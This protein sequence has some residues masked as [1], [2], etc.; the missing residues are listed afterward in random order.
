MES[1]WL[2]GAQ[3]A[4]QCVSAVVRPGSSFEGH[5]S[6]KISSLLEGLAA[7]HHHYG[8]GGS[9][10]TANST[11]TLTPEN[12]ALPKQAA[13]VALV[14]PVLD[15]DISELLHRKGVFEL[16]V[17]DHPEKL[18]ALFMNVSSWSGVA[19][20]LVESGVAHLIDAEHAPHSRGRRL[21]AGMFGVAKPGSDLRRVR[22]D[23]RRK[24]ACDFSLREVTCAEALKASW[25]TSRMLSALR[26]MTLPHSLQLKDLFLR[27]RS[28]LWITTKDAKDYFYLMQLPHW[29]REATIVGWPVLRHEVPAHMCRHL[30]QTCD[31]LV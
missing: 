4:A 7:E 5:G 22:I 9:A 28:R 29:Q 27:R 20:R 30:A 2:P 17:S 14:P 24:N 8:L 16:P 12:M 21:A 13:I 18:P 10:L 11:L 6:G 19:C 23:R 3:S 25:P 15:P 31:K 26:R 1:R